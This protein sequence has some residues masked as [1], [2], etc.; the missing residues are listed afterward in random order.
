M[1]KDPAETAKIIEL[2]EGFYVRQ[3]V[4]NI[5]WIDLGE[6]AIVID[7]LE[8]RSLEREVFQAI[9]STLPKRPIFY[10]LNTHTHYDHV[11]LNEAF[12]RRCGAKIVNPS[13]SRIEPDGRWF[14]G[15]HR[16]AH[17]LPLTGLHTNEDCV[18]WLPDDR[19]LFTGD[20]FGWGLIPTGRV[21][22][23]S[24]AQLEQTYQRM[25]EFDAA[26][27]V[28]GHGPICTTAE[29]I[30]WVEYFRWLRDQVTA[31]CQAGESDG[32]IR[33]AL[34]PPAD[35]ADWWRFTLWKHEDSL[36]KVL[37]SVRKG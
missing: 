14:E 19:V 16:R 18:V 29:L 3:A 37:R 13:N 22:P 32:Q 36:N 17:M 27:V 8:E 15:S 1:V 33:A 4:D 24:A 21:T 25:I 28:P 9:E 34:T 11:A 35:M 26:T 2:G 5:A 30:R 7:A 10:V 6:W 31:R 23:D 20:L 12:E